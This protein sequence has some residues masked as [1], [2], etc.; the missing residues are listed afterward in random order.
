MSS[1]EWGYTTQNTQYVSFGN[2][3]QKAATKAKAAKEEFM[4]FMNM[5]TAEKMRAL[6]L[7]EMG[8]TEEQ[9]K[10]LSPEERKKIEEE[11]LERIKKKMEASGL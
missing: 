6:V 2:P 3:N 4:A 1:L 9:V 11:I 7:K 10:N 8:L 5:S